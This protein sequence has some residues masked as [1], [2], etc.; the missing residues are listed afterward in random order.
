MGP[1]R[2]RPQRTAG[3]CRRG[4]RFAAWDDPRLRACVG[5]LL[6]WNIAQLVGWIGLLHR[7]ELPEDRTLASPRDVSELLHDWAERGRTPL[8]PVDGAACRCRV[9]GARARSADG[10][11]RGDPEAALLTP[12]VVLSV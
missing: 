4:G 8:C 5:I 6:R 1:H 7:P 9:G 2:N 12:A 3:I 11:P 10:A